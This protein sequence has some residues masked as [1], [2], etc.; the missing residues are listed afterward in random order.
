[1]AR[2][3]PSQCSR[4]VETFCCLFVCFPCST[5]SCNLARS[6]IAHT[7]HRRCDE[8]LQRRQ[9]ARRVARFVRRYRFGCSGNATESDRSLRVALYPIL[10]S[11]AS[12]LNDVVESTNSVTTSA[13]TLTSAAAHDDDDDN[14]VARRRSTSAL[15]RWSVSE[16]NAL[17]ARLHEL[18]SV[19]LPIVTDCF[20]IL[21]VSIFF[22]FV[23][24]F[25]ICLFVCFFTVSLANV[26]ECS[27][28]RRRKR[29]SMP[30]ARLEHRTKQQDNFRR[31]D[32]QH[33]C[34]FVFLVSVRV[35]RRQCISR[36]RRI[37]FFFFFFFFCFDFAF[38]VY[39][40]IT[41]GSESQSFSTI[42]ALLYVCTRAISHF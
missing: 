35:G 19:A 30:F 7:T 21:V 13:S 41:L 2:S 27:C 10:M 3:A 20:G 42:A 6:N 34:A 32:A 33:V 9:A 29:A 15:A 12:A 23:L 39:S 26:S 17:A 18:L 40:N 4:P 37:W 16:R 14:E 5:T 28:C 25:C 38:S 36:Q 8:L 1:M 31:F 22:F 11:L 24:L